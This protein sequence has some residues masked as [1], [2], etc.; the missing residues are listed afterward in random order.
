MLFLLLVAFML[1]AYAPVAA[2]YSSFVATACH[3]GAGD[4]FETIRAER[5]RMPFGLQR[6]VR[7]ELLP[8]GTGV[9]ATFMGLRSSVA[10]WDPELG[11]TR[12][13]PAARAPVKRGR[14]APALP[15]SAQS[16][17]RLTDVVDGCFGEGSG[18]HAVAILQRGEVLAERYATGYTSTTRL[19]GWSMTKSMTAT[20]IARLLRSNVLENLDQPA[21]VAEWSGVDPRGAITLRDL[22]QMQSGL[23]FD[24]TYELPWSDSLQM[25]FVSEDVAA[26]SAA[27]P[28]L[29]PR[30][31]VWSYSDGTS[32]ILARIVHLHAGSSDAER[33]GFARRALFEPLGM[34]TALVGVDRTGVFVGSSLMQAST[35]DWLRFGS[36]YLSDGVVAGERLLPEGWVDFVSTTSTNDVYGAHFWLFKDSAAHE[37]DGAFYASGFGGQVLG[38]DPARELLFLRMGVAPDDGKFDAD[39]FARAVI[40]ALE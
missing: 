35:D 14:R 23:E 19:L 30:G 18:T 7:L 11:T 34:S 25:L 8:A 21:P 5:M 6:L 3:F 22:L 9:K 39:A 13:K 26:Y 38:I 2:G 4:S 32:N 36:L 27:K 12:T 17:P 28:Q 24:S 40:G 20:L 10:Y 33:A 1:R 16:S 31:T 29:H 37:L 15:R